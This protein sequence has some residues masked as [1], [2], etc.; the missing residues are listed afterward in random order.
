VTIRPA[1]VVPGVAQIQIR[2]LSG[3][4]KDIQLTPTPVTG[5]A[6][7]HPPTA[8]VATRSAADPR[9]FDGSLWLMAAGAW[10]V[11]IHATGA[12]GQGD[13]VVPVPAVA[14]KIAPMT[15]G[16][17]YFLTGMMVFLVVGMVAIV[18]AGVRES[19][20]EPGLPAPR[21]TPKTFAAMGLAVVLLMLVLWG[22]NAWW[23]SDAHDF[24]RRVY[25]PLEVS[26]VVK[27]AGHADFKLSDPGWIA[28]RKLDDLIPDHGHMMHLF[29]IRWPAMDEVFHLH[30]E[31]TAPGFF[32]MDLPSLPAGDYKIFAD[33]VHDTG[34]DE[35]AVGNV[36]LPEIHGKPLDGDDAGGPATA[37]L[38]NGYKMV[39]QREK[40][41]P[42]PAKQLMLFSFAI[43]GP[44]GKPVDDL[45]PYMGMGG[46]A[47]F[48]KRDGSVF[49]HVHPTGSASMASVAVASPAAMGAMH[50][51]EIG[52]SVSFPY[53]VP[54]PGAYRI[55]VQLKRAGKVE[56]GTFDLDV[57]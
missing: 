28:L 24:Q 51:T 22:G 56:T 2:S 27:G 4:V 29:L 44:D 39:W 5:E 15:S 20:L 7:K 19:R 55:F 21:W 13:M 52:H 23:A 18:G 33:I 10:A 37:D 12:A 35:T 30:P 11:H 36:T 25:K 9:I 53:G 3:G 47:E 48:V 40:S 8:D 6:A 50:Q 46:H 34:L 49:A 31:Q 17:G 32:S 54:A 1:D 43:T 45:E 14:M 16:V 42:V 41:G 26:A 38:G 57:N